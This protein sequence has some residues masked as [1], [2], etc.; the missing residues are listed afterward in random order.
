M[1]RIATLAAL[2]LLSS[3]TAWAADA[4]PD[5]QAEMKKMQEAQA[6]LMAAMMVEKQSRL[7][8][9]ETVAALQDAAKKRGWEVG[10][11]MDM[12]EA[13]IKAGQKNAKPFKMLVMCNKDLAESLIKAQ[14]AQK[15]M[16][17][18]PCRLSVFEGTDG[19]VYIAKTNTE[20][21]AQMAAPAFAPLLKKFAEEENAVLAKITE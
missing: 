5:T 13:M 4:K 9:N 11:V 2:L 19:K 8:F 15:A 7:G 12:Q 1:K 20:F 18:A 10:P 6:K 21:M 3:H 14:V 17:F 16:P